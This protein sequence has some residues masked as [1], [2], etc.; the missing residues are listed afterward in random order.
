MQ[1][2]PVGAPSPWPTHEPA[3]TNGTAL[4]A[5]LSSLSGFLCLF[6]LGGALGVI[7]GLIARGEITRAA[8][9]ESGRKLASVAIVLGVLNVGLAVIGVA[10]GITCLARPTPIS[11]ARR[12]P[13]AVTAPAWPAPSVVPPR[14]RGA[15]PLPPARSSRESGDQVTHLG[16]ITVVDL[17]GELSAALDAQRTA[18]SAASETLVLWLVVADCKP[19]DGVAASLTNPATQKALG[20]VR[21][22]RADRDEF[23]SDLERLGIPTEKIPGFA[24]LDPRNH[25]RDFIHG[26]EWDADTASN[27]AP[28]LG[29]FVH[30]RYL[31]RRQPWHGP[32]RDDETPL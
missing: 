26:G 22:V 16:A 3:K 14:P 18:A 31:K 5:L 29:K 32:A 9:R 11:A 10:V 8:G 13:T 12:A 2:P 28:V 21:F 30:G 23:E 1:S 27:I 6:G 15:A 7:L 4:V 24:L 25:A 20:A 19:C 17:S